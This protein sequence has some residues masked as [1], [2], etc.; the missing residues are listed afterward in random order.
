[1]DGPRGE[2]AT[3]GVPRGPPTGPPSNTRARFTREPSELLLLCILR[4]KNACRKDELKHEQKEKKKT[5]FDL[6]GSV[7]KRSRWHESKHMVSERG[8]GVLGADVE[9]LFMR[10]S[11]PQGP[12]WIGERTDVPRGGGATWGELSLPSTGVV[13][14]TTTGLTR[15]KIK[16][17]KGVRWDPVSRKIYGGLTAVFRDQ[18]LSLGIIIT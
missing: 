13:P 6:R 9:I 14:N 5:A 17:L 3:R 7:A 4:S 1:M 18:T 11:T 16:P 2:P 12:S 15:T 10:P 8:R